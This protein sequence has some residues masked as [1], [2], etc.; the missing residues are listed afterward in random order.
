LTRVDTI[1]RPSFGIW[2]TSETRRHDLPLQTNDYDCG[3]FIARYIDYLAQGL[4]P[5]FKETEM[6]EFRIFVKTSILNNTL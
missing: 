3:L 5:N 2:I 1:H 4:I 6:V